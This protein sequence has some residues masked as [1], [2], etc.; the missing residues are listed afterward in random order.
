MK[1]TK[2]MREYVVGKVREQEDILMAKVEEEYADYYLLQEKTIEEIKNM[3]EEMNTKA[4]RIFQ[5]RGFIENPTYRTFTYSDYYIRNKKI[6]DEIQKKKM[7]IRSATNTKLR[8]LLLEIEL[9]AAKSEFLDI[10]NNF[11]LEI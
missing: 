11:S 6:E 10:V 8:N 2:A 7:E 3:C 1:L 4:A 5:E 9:G